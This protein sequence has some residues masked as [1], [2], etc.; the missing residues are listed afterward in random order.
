MARPAAAVS[1]G[2]LAGAKAPAA[3]GGASLRAGPGPH[4]L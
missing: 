2:G 4:H 1:L 3:L